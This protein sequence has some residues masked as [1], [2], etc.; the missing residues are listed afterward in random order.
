MASHI[1]P[2]YILF[3]S[4]KVNVFFS[5]KESFS[6]NSFILA[7]LASCKKKRVGFSFLKSKSALTINNNKFAW[8][9]EIFFIRGK[10]VFSIF[11]Q[12]YIFFLSL[13]WNTHK[14]FTLWSPNLRK[15]CTVQT[16]SQKTA[17]DD[18]D[19]SLLSFSICQIK[20]I[21]DCRLYGE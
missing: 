15:R 11:L 7:E 2:P 21:F 18:T 17:S 13:T 10:S 12:H 1:T 5:E 8:F 14:L 3:T 9:E 19:Q 16:V 20:N 4:W 6:F